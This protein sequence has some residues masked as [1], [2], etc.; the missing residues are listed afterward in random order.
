MNKEIYKNKYQEIHTTL[1]I[2]EEEIEKHLLDKNDIINNRE[3]MEELE[4]RVLEA[5]NELNKTREDER[6]IFNY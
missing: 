4:R 5:V 6:R 3:K 1:N 2:L